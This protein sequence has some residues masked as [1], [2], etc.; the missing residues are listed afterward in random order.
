ML[1]LPLFRQT[2]ETHIVPGHL[3]VAE[4]CIVP[5][6]APL[7]G[8]VSTQPVAAISNSSRLIYFLLGAPVFAN[9]DFV[10]RAC[11]NTHDKCYSGTRMYRKALAAIGVVSLCLLLII[12]QTSTPAQVGPF[13][14]LF[15]FG[16]LL[17]SLASLMT[18]FVYYGRRIVARFTRISI[19][20]QQSFRSVFYYSFVISIALVILVALRS[21]NSLSLYEIGLVTLLVVLGI[22]YIRRVL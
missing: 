2:G 8:A 14:T 18:F 12:L 21:I 9:H 22:F 4:L 19:R 13:G 5:T 20:G 6:Y 3:G 10:V 7:A 16:L 11:P 17:T 1:A 15:V